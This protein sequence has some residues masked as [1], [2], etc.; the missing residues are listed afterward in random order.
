MKTRKRVRRMR[1]WKTARDEDLIEQMA[2]EVAD[3]RWQDS[4]KRASEFIF[5]V[6]GYSVRAHN[7]QVVLRDDSGEAVGVLFPN[8]ADDMEKIWGAESQGIPVDLVAISRGHTIQYP[9]IH[10]PEEW[11]FYHVLWVEWVDGIAY[12]KG[13]GQVFR[14]AWKQ[15]GAK[16]VPG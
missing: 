10:H 5:K 3:I 9:Q 12:R 14:S 6:C 11:N 1:T 16:D 4:D 7:C 15:L 13:V 8:L 2:K